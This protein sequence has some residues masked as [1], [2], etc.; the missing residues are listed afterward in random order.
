LPEKWHEGYGGYTID[1]LKS[2]IAG[3]LALN[4]P[5]TVLLL[6]GTNDASG[7]MDMPNAPARLGS[8]LDTILASPSVSNIK[9]S[10]I[11]PFNLNWPAGNQMVV[12]FN[13]A[14]PG[15]VNA[16]PRVK[17]VDLWPLINTATDM[18][19][20]VHLN[21]NGQAKLARLFA[22]A[23]TGTSSAAVATNSATA[24]TLTAATI[25]GN[26]VSLG[27][28]ASMTVGFLWG[29]SPTLA[30]ATNVTVG[31]LSAPGAFNNGLTG[32][33]TS[34]TYYFRAWANGNGFFTG[35]ILSFI[36]NTPGSVTTNAA[37]S[38]TLAT[39]TLNGN[40]VTLGSA[41][42]M[43][44]GFRWGTSPTLAGN[45]TVATFTS[46]QTFSTDLSNLAPVTTYYFLAW[47]NGN[48]YV[49]GVVLSFTTLGPPPPPSVGGGGGGG[50]PVTCPPGYLLSG[51]NC[52]PMPKAPVVGTGGFLFPMK[53]LPPMAMGVGGFA[54]LGSHSPRKRPGVRALIGLSVL[55]V[56]AIFALGI[57]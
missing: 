17:L 44:V 3:K 48:P 46:P 33:S 9:V 15:I 25:N 8:L 36:T 18:A 49:T 55:V 31:T 12:D 39:A 1:N 10:T 32:L 38:I 5:D 54:V 16:R 30:G 34:T 57:R 41:S 14:M 35:S 19:D 29:T 4:P 52:L 42:S 23:V 53:F 11:P 20:D 51:I 22:D 37:T 7:S 56:A 21:C 6:I 40:L 24:I 26:L 45:V 28:A 13:N 47:A 2:I 43:V 50:G 27:G